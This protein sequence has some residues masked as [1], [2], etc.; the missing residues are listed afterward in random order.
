MKLIGLTGKAMGQSEDNS[1]ARSWKRVGSKPQYPRHGSTALKVV[2][3]DRLEKSVSNM[4]GCRDRRRWEFLR[5]KWLPLLDDLRR[6][7]AVLDR[8]EN[9][10]LEAEAKAQAR[11]KAERSNLGGDASIDHDG[12]R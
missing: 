1:N 4:K 7:L 3:N 11:A 8:E 2:R 6:T 10:L 12:A 9:E 5:T